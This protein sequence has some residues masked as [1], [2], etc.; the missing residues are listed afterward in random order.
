MKSIFECTA[1]HRAACPV[2]LDELP[3][4]IRKRT[5]WDYSF[6]QTDSGCFL[7]PTFRDMPY[8]NSFVP[9]IDMVISRNDTQTVLHF[10]GQPVK[11]IRIFMGFWFGFLLPMELLFL[12]LAFTSHMDSLFPVFI[13]LIMMVFGY[14]LCKLATRA[15]FHSIVKA[16]QNI[17]R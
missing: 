3:A 12:V 7:K 11:A 13:P 2:V 6:T 1:E 16:I 17:S 10:R 5:G 4:V 9:E 8:H 14:L 15:I